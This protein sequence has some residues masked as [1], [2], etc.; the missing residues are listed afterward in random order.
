MWVKGHPRSLKA[1][2]FENV[3]TR[4]PIASNTRPN[5]GDILYHLLDI[6][7]YWSK[8]AKFLYRTV[9]VFSAPHGVTLTD[10]DPV[11]ISRRCL[12]LLKLE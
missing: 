1:A 12:I 6:A 8:I 4:F 3:G 7:S 11:G 2:P 5:Y 10:P 9:P